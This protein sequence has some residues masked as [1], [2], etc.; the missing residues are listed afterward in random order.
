MIKKIA[1]FL[2]AALVII[3]FIRPA[4]NISTAESPNH[5]SNKY[6][7]PTSIN[8]IMQKACYDCH[9]NNTVYPWYAN[10]QPVGFWLDD[11]VKDGKGELNFS[12]FLTYSPKKARHKMEEVVEQVKES[13]MPLN[14][15]TW[16]HRDADLTPDERTEIVAWADN[17]AKQIARE[18]NLPPSE[19]KKPA[20][21]N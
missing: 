10:I 12:E 2:L 9:S 14:S 7:V 11:H 17:L 13:E 16:I 1:Y 21:E 15:Y 5:I 4:R 8:D 19:P 6:A 18:N 20:K 3:Q